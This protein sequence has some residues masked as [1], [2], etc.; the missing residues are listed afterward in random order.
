MMDA[1][2]DK[3]A[4]ELG[5]SSFLVG[6]RFTVADLTAASI[7][8]NIVRPDDYPYPWTPAP[9]SFAALAARYEDHSATHWVRRLYARHRS[10]SAEQTGDPA[11]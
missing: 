11:P 7:L 8:A 2:F 1:I 6:E 3:V 5:A 10:P 4:T 9:P